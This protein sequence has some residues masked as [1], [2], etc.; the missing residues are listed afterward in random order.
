MV[1]FHPCFVAEPLSIPDVRSFY[2]LLGR[3]IT[4]Q[5]NW[6]YF[7]ILTYFYSFE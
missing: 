5:L 1:L 4:D 3:K 2:A 6:I 7:D